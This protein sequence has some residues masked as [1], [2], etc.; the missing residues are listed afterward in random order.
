VKVKADAL[1]DYADMLVTTMSIF[2]D[3]M[4]EADMEETER[5]IEAVRNRGHQIKKGS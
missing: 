4:T 1:F 2:G 5:W 3:S